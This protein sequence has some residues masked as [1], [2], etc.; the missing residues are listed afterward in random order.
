MKGIIGAIC[1]DIIGSTREFNPIKTK[2]FKL[3]EKHS[4]FTD[5]TVVTMAVASWLINDD[6]H[7]T[8]NLVKEIQKLTREFPYVQYGKRFNDWIRSKNPEPYGSWANGSAMRVSP[9]AWVCESLEE[10]QMLAKK[11]S[12]ITHNHPEGIK[13]AIATASAIYLARKNK[14]KEFIK[15]YI[16][17]T[18][19][20]DL[21]RHVDDIRE[22]YEY[23]V[24]CKKSVPESIICFLESD[25]YIDTIRNAISLGGDADTMAAIS[26]SIAAAY[27]EVPEDLIFDCIDRLDDKLFEIYL[28]YDDK[29]FNENP[30]WKAFSNID[31]DIPFETIEFDNGTEILIEYVTGEEELPDNYNG[32]YTCKYRRMK[33]LDDGVLKSEKFEENPNYSGDADTLNDKWQRSHINEE[34][35]ENALEIIHEGLELADIKKRILNDESYMVVICKKGNPPLPID[36]GLFK[37]ITLSLIDN[38]VTL[39][40]LT[41]NVIH[42]ING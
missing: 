33:L 38:S 20:Y 6:K 25:S 36:L 8:E 22:D 13:G 41:F 29:F 5:D 39:A 42:E 10:T 31:G 37:D 24:S 21:S 4:S 40:E 28:E 23:E 26:G 35:Q 27:Y 12:E 30:V 19:N 9:V 14:N 7:L 2:D 18:F 34:F 1:G 11:S 16:E 17:A 15:E 3:I 32:K